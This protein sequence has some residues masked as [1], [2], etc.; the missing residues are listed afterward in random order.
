MVESK[1]LIRAPESEKTLASQP[2]N[3]LIIRELEMLAKLDQIG[4]MKE[5]PVGG[6]THIYDEV[7][8]AIAGVATREIDGVA[9]VGAGSL[10]RNLSE[11]L[12][13]A[14]RRARGV[15]VEA[16]SKEAILD[17]SIRVYYG[18]NILAI[19]ASTRRNVAERL[20]RLCGLIAKEINIKVVGLDFPA[21]MPGRVQ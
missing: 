10:V 13:G 15:E 20:V 16:G 12:G 4:R 3:G 14:E 19:V 21:R 17:L 11:R 6:R 1:E 8:A 9:A 5:I 2:I 7:I 18:N